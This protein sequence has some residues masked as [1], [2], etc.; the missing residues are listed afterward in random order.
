VEFVESDFLSTAGFALRFSATSWVIGTFLGPLLKAKELLPLLAPSFGE[1]FNAIARGA[2]FA[3]SG[4][5]ALAIWDP[6]ARW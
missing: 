5:P 4:I 3:T 2:A 6:D 1:V